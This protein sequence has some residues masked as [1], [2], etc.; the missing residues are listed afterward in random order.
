MHEWAK[1]IV[2]CVKTKVD[3]IGLDN[4]DNGSLC[5]LEM[6]TKIAKNITCFEKDYEIIKAMK[7]NPQAEYS[8]NKYGEIRYYQEPKPYYMDD[9]YEVDKDWYRKPPKELRDMDR[10]HGRM[11]YTE[12]MDN[13]NHNGN[14][15]QQHDSR[16]GRNGES[17]RRYYD[18]MQNHKANTPEDKAMKVKDLDMWMTDFASD[19][20]ELLGD[21]TADE[22]TMIRT[23][24]E[25]LKNSI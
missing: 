16:M 23:K 4:L 5:E 18:S 25:N 20:K 2:D 22:K 6:W 8:F 15:N 17:R 7:E 3:G 19:V 11:Y 24:L 9:R 10:M 13:Q 1:Q 21:M 14:T 12:P